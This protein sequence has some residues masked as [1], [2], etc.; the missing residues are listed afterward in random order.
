MTSE[1]L[2]T[3][4][5]QIRA[6]CR[7]RHLSYHTEKAYVGWATRY[8]DF[9]KNQHP[10]NLNPRCI[11]EYL[12][13]LAVHRNV[14]ASTQNQALSALVFLYRDV[15]KLPVDTLEEFHYASKPRTLPT[16]L[17]AEETQRVIHHL[18]GS[19]RLV[20]SLLYGSGL[21][22][23]EAVRLRVKDVDFE[24]G[25]IL[26]RQGKGRKDRITML[27][28]SLTR[29]LRRQ[30]DKAHI[31]HDED[32]EAGHGAVYLPNALQRKL[33][34]AATDWAWQYVFPSRNLSIDPRSNT[35]RRH[36]ISESLI[37]KRVKKA[38]AKANIDKYAGCHTLRHSF[39]THLLEKGY[40]IR[41]VQELLGHK[42]VRTT[43]IY[44]HVLN[45]GIYVRSPLD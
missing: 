11:S 26:V 5:E 13:H 39:A 6:T 12:T 21:R 43:Q 30:L 34:N 3:I 9:F 17:T 35:I 19:C 27:P 41:T 23:I 40:D 15:L 36:H 1:E 10:I 45:K 18:E 32:L 29:P 44:T 20:A 31:I 2:E 14:A 4:L 38:V 16:V 33:P 42:D 22:L 7:L 25:Q 8:L 37:R 24:Y 28:E